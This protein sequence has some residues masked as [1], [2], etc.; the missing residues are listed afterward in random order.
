[1]AAKKIILSKR[2]DNL[3][4][5]KVIP[6]GVFT[7]KKILWETLTKLDPEIEQRFIYDDVSEKSAEANY[8]RLCGLLTKS[9]RVH[10]LTEDRL[11]PLFFII[12]CEENVIRSS[13]FNEDGHPIYN[14][15]VK[16]NEGA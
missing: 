5:G 1:M 15:A 6:V 4:A 9:G 2:D 8:T 14:P 16:K 11:I 3:P 7:Q 12:E 10:I 13:D